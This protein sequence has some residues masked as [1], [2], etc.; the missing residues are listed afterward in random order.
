MQSSKAH[1]RE[2]RLQVNHSTEFLPRL[3]R[4]RVKKGGA[5]KSEGGR[6]GGEGIEGSEKSNLRNVASLSCF[7]APAFN[8]R[9]ERVP[10]T[11]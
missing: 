9:V 6:S 4:D 5:T 11:C 8:W 1:C 10:S 3:P 7:D 2:L